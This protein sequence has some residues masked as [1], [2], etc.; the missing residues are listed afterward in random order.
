MTRQLR[1]VQ[2]CNSFRKRARITHA[3]ADARFENTSK[4]RKISCVR[5]RK[6][7][8][9][10]TIW[11]TN[12]WS[13]TKLHKIDFL[14]STNRFS[15]S[16]THKKQKTKRE[17]RKCSPQL[18]KA[19]TT[20][21]YKKRNK[22]QHS[23]WRGMKHATLAWNTESSQTRHPSMSNLQQPTT[24]DIIAS[25]RKCKQTRDNNRVSRRRQKHTTHQSWIRHQR[26][27]I[28]LMSLQPPNRKLECYNYRSRLQIPQQSSET[29]KTALNRSD[30]T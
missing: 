17:H 3:R 11:T 4:T 7:A 13:E 20:A 30:V 16:V 1:C 27:L 28:S 29:E 10:H 9:L 12:Q 23:Q 24:V 19:D 6:H 26:Q 5:R 25:K 15:G 14:W 22:T 21:T 18:E 8:N 2:R